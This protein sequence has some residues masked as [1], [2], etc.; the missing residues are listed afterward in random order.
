MN[1]PGQR[2]R[3]ESPLTP[4]PKSLPGTLHKDIPEYLLSFVTALGACG[5]FITLVYNLKQG[6]ANGKKIEG[7]HDEVNSTALASVKRIEQLSSALADSDVSIPRT[8]PVDDA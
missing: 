4:S 6:R 8:P 2:R 3:C 5:G 1:R 7:V